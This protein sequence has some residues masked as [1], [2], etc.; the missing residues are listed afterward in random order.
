VYVCGPG[1]SFVLIL[2]LDPRT[3]CPRGDC[4]T[5]ELAATS[6]IPD[7]AEAGRVGLAL[8][9]ELYGRD[10]S[11]KMG[12]M[13]ADIKQDVIESIAHM[14][15]HVRS[16]Q[17][18]QTNE[19]SAVTALKAQLRT[20]RGRAKTA[21][22]NMAAAQEEGA[23]IAASCTAVRAAA[24]QLVDALAQSASGKKHGEAQ[25]AQPTTR[26]PALP[27]EGK[28]ADAGT[29]WVVAAVATIGAAYFALH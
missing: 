9:S 23:G 17:E 20:Q 26:T 4:S 8:H 13:A 6:D 10:G 11:T 7:V 27:T 21:G 29:A 15:Q 2:S 14:I 12:G 1:G 19:A 24:T 28:A 18:A 5:F 16:L 25:R 3:F 22:A